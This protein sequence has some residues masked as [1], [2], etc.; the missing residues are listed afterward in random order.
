MQQD[1]TALPQLLP[2]QMPPPAPVK[3][4]RPV[5]NF[6]PFLLAIIAA[7]V[8]VLSVLLLPYLLSQIFEATPNLTKGGDV[9]GGLTAF[10][11]ITSPLML[12]IT[13]SVISIIIALG[14]VGILRARK[15]TKYKT[16][17]IV[18]NVFVIILGVGF[19]IFSLNLKI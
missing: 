7:V 12:I 15:N 18:V 2:P 14:I 4:V 17:A 10:F 11:F 1:S 19:A 5:D 3:P 13:F 8:F 16:A 9:L 6:R